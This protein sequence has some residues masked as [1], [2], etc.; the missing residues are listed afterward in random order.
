MRYLVLVINGP[1]LNLLGERAPEL[2]GRATLRQIEAALRVRARQRET[3]LVCMQSNHEGAIIDFLHAWR[4][5]AQGLVINPGAFAHYSYA[6][7]EAIAA[8]R[9]P[10]VEVHLTDLAARPEP[11]RRVSVIRDVCVATVMGRGPRGY[12]DA[13]DLLLDRLGAQPWYHPHLAISVG[14]ARPRPAARGGVAAAGPHEPRQPAPS[15]RRR[16]W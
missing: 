2:Y 12:L 7:R 5:R 11:W 3:A 10:A 13:L 1:N 6:I 8:V 4:R 15:R 9:L 14:L 16:P